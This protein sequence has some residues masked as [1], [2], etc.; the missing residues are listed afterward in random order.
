MYE[1]VLFFLFAKSEAL[2][3]WLKFSEVVCYLFILYAK[4]MKLQANLKQ[5]RY[6]NE[7]KSIYLHIGLQN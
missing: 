5:W 3:K 2:S 7:N 1:I 6:F 4:S